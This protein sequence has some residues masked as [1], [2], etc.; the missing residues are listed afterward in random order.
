MRKAVR[1]IVVKD[2]MLLVMHRN[3]FGDKYFTLVGGRV[4]SDESIIEALYREVKEETSLTISNPRLVYIE[5]AEAPFGRQYIFLCTYSIGSIALHESSEEAKIHALGSNLY[6]P[7]WLPV[8]NLPDAPFMPGALKSVIIQD[9][10]NGFPEQPKMIK[11]E[12]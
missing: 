10:L 9:L 1:A 8:A 3:K 4:K 6:N 5:E 7:M 12:V 11:V 2:D